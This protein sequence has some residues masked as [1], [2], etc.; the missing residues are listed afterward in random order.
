[1]AAYYEGVEGEEYPEKPLHEEVSYPS[2]SV[3]L[4]GDPAGVK[5]SG[6]GSGGKDPSVGALTFSEPLGVH[7]VSCTLPTSEREVCGAI[8]AAALASAPAVG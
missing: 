2:S 4:F 5:G 3:A 6:V 8:V 1:V 7:K